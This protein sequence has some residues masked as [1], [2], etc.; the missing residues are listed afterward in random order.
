MAAP[1]LGGLLI[2]DEV[3][4]IFLPV[5]FY[6]VEGAP[7]EKAA[8]SKPA[9]RRDR[10]DRTIERSKEPAIMNTDKNPT[11]DT[12]PETDHPA[13]KSSG[14]SRFW[15]AVKVVEVRMRF[16]AVL[17]IS[18]AL[19]GYWD[20]IKNHY[21]KYTRPAGA[22]AAAAAK[23]TVEYFCPMHTFIVRDHFGKCPICGMDLVKRK[24][25][26]K[27]DLPAGVVARVQVSPLQIA[28]AGVKTEEV[29]ARVSDARNAG[30]RAGG[31]ERV[32]AGH[33]RTTVSPAASRKLL[34]NYVGA[35]VRKG[36]ALAQI[37][38]PEFVAAA[39]EYLLALS[40]GT[41]TG[42]SRVQATRERLLLAGFTDAQV[43]D[44]ARTR[45]VPRSSPTISPIGGTVLEKKAVEG[46]Y[47]EQGAPLFSVADLSPRLGAGARARVGPGGCEAGA[48]CR[49]DDPWR[50]PTSCSSAMS[51]SST[52]S[53]SPKAAR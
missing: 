39:E 22:V 8:R 16:V 9:T 7:L 33:H 13:T 17:V 11:P 4:D 35:Q 40:S 21:D 44:L 47:L 10:T 42:S 32:G 28:E 37:Y 31:T 53:S 27:E 38:S 3:I 6:Q 24:K 30:N 49:G 14:W 46:D 29:A 43:A 45:Q 20:V 48:A 26:E 25:G 5:L 36:D 19:I 2:A 52:R 51:A 50:I 34:V 15:F 41:S 1:V 23:A 12:P 18:G